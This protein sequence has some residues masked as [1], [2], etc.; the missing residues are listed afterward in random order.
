MTAAHDVAVA[1]Q[2]P[3]FDACASPGGEATPPG[4][5]RVHRDARL[6]PCH[7][8]RYRLERSWSDGPRMTLVLLNP[9]RADGVE[10]DATTR[11][12]VG[13][14][15]AVGCGGAD[16]VNLMAWR[17]H[18]PRALRRAADPIG[19]TNYSW[20]SAT[21]AANVP[22]PIVVAWGAWAA[23]W[24][25]VQAVLD[26]LDGYPLLC[27]GVTKNGHP[28][29]PLYVASGTPLLPFDPAPLSMAAC[30]AGF[31]R[32]GLWTPIPADLKEGLAGRVCRCGA[33]QV[34]A[35]DCL[36]RLPKQ[37]TDQQ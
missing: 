23:G 26:L 17:S 3:L 19:P 5:G 29:H 32:W 8:Y 34:V 37:E 28:R 25:R 24:D 16:L 30:R 33:D 11:R 22:G 10:D 12:C 31:H 35:A 9:S 13:F 36:T 21:V 4:S 1:V 6:S 2:Q 20:I 15:R 14:A 7:A 27:L 18:D